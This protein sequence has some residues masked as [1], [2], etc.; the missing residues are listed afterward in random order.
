MRSPVVVVGLVL[1]QHGTKV[2][3]IDDD[4]MIQA[5]SA[6]CAYHSFGDRVRLGCP[7]RGQ[8]G[9]D[10]QPSCPCI[11]APTIAAVAIPYE[12]RAARR[13]EHRTKR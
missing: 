9:F 11:E 6:K 7:D 12:E 8:Y 5:L 10:A 13:A 2:P 1:P 4:H 3:L